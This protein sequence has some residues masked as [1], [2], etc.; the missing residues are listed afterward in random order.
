MLERSKFCNFCLI[1]KCSF[2]PCIIDSS[3]GMVQKCWINDKKGKAAEMCTR[4]I[5]VVIMYS[6]FLNN[7]AIGVGY[8]SFHTRAGCFCEDVSVRVCVC[9][10]ALL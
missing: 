9:K 5:A 7:V 1:I 10:L 3:V 8:K 6:T 2:V 4:D